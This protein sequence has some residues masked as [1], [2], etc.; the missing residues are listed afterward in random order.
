MATYVRSMFAGK[1]LCE[2]DLTCAAC[3][4]DM[5]DEAAGSPSI[6]FSDFRRG[7]LIVDRQGVRLFYTAKRVGGGVQHFDA[8]KVLKFAVS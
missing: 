8:I 7:Y 3:I 2:A 6:A 1:S 5:P 4:A